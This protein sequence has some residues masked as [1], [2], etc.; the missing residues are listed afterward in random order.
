ML[1]MLSVGLYLPADDKG[2]III[3]KSAFQND[4]SQTGF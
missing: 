2:R 3:A 4:S 1:L